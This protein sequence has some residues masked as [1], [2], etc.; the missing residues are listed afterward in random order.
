MLDRVSLSGFAPSP[1]RGTPVNA[2][3][4]F[5]V[6]WLI[7]VPVSAD[8]PTSPPS[9]S[10]TIEV[11]SRFS[12][13]DTLSCHEE[14]CEDARDC[15]DGLS[16]TPSEFTV[17]CE[18]AEAGYGDWL[19]RFPTP[20]PVGSATNDLVA[21]EW[22]AARDGDGSIVNAPAIVV[23]HES[24]RGMIVG[25]LVAQGLSSQGLHAFMLHLPGYGARTLVKDRDL[26]ITQALATLTQA[27]ADVR[28]A[29][30]AV[31]ALPH[32]DDTTIGLQG[33]SLGGFVVATVAGMDAG[34]DRIFILLAGG[35][36]HEV[37]LSGAKDAARI[38]RQLEQVGVGADE[39]VELARPIEPMRLAHRI[40]SESL[41][42]YSGKNDDVVPPASSKALAT[43]ARLPA[44]HHIEMTA[45]H[46]SGIIYLPLV[47]KQIREKMRVE[48]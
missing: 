45:D 11:G 24:G 5:V 42:I 43:A 15:L 8:E 34:F 10:S 31:V 3:R 27:I 47:L 6:A 44:G 48:K 14:T 32:V 29:R 30:D 12:A 38:R 41:W 16:W 22:Y 46:Y 28:R 36:V 40:N 33:T 4:W 21:L 19:I 7:S 39:I 35:N 18:S 23:V 20:K 26:D 37:L 17:H 9:A 1:E 13:T 25:R 2:V